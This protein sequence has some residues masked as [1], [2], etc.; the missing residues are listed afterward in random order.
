MTAEYFAPAFS[1]EINGTAVVADISAS[2]TDVTVNSESGRIDSCQLTLVNPYPLLPWT[3]TDDMELFKEGN[4]ITVKM[5]YTDQLQ[6]MFDGEITG[7]TPTFP[8]SGHPTVQVEAQN[9]MHRLQ[10]NSCLVDFKDSTDGDIVRRI[11]KESDLSAEVDDPGTTFPKVSTGHRTH[12]DFLME[13][14]RAAN[15]EMWVEGMTLHFAEPRATIPAEYTLVWGRTAQSFTPGSLPLQSFSPTLDASRQVSTVIVRGQ[16]PLTRELIEGRATAGDEDTK[17]GGAQ[18]GPEARG[19]AFGGPN[20]WVVVNVPVSSQAEAEQRARALYNARAME[21]VQ[22][23]GATVGLPGLRAGMVVS[24]DG[25]GPRFNG[26]Y[27]VTRTTHTL[28]GG[29]YRTSFSVRKNSVGA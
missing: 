19:A 16:D 2:I 26:E 28:G 3:H 4:A 29:G 13:R 11:A 18:T 7:M 5:G 9:R 21:F 27:F 25:L 23:T 6:V 22:G 1:V 17:L 15:R 10:S 8:E 24:I 20:E 12:L 14:A